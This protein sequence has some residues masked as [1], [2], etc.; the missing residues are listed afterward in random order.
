MSDGKVASRI[1]IVFLAM[2]ESIMSRYSIS[3]D[4]E[5]S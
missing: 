5:S 1:N 2:A 3:L 4:G